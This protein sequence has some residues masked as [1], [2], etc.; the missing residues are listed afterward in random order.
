MAQAARITEYAFIIDPSDNAYTFLYDPAKSLGTRDRVVT[1]GTLRSVLVTGAYVPTSRTINSKALSSNIVLTPSD[2]G[3]VPTS[4]TVNGYSLLS[5]ISLDASD[6]GLGN[7]SNVAQLPLSYLDVD[8]NMTAN[9][10]VRVPSQAAVKTF[11][12]SQT[13]ALTWG[14]ITG[15]LAFQTD[16]NSA[17]AAKVPTSRTVNGYALSSNISI[18]ASDVSLGNVSNVA[19]M[20]LTYLDT[21]ANMAA[22]SNTKV[23]SQAAVVSYVAAQ[24]G[25]GGG[26]WGSITGTLS[27]QTDLQTALDAR[28]PLTNL[29]S[30][31]TS[32]QIP[33]YSGT[34]GKVLT[35]ATGT[36]ILRID[37]GVLSTTTNGSTLTTLNASNLSSGTVAAARGGA[38]TTSGVLKANGSGTVSAATSTDI[39]TLY[40]YTPLNSTVLAGTS[41]ITVGA[42]QP[43]SPAVGDIWVDITGL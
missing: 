15:T 11:V 20:P 39:D 12:E 31:V 36:G 40:G 33:L 8:S 3:A 43:S 18:S 16:L 2:I 35:N 23:P 17:L 41:K 6:I 4:S 34:T 26:T 42:T 27:Q 28:M 5:S 13:P 30:S 22:N 25:G 37:T 1:L 24:G 38:G 32:G 10:D 7:V 29:P 21:D 14:S 19:Q 9:S